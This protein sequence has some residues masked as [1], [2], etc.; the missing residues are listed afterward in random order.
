MHIIRY[1]LLA[2]FLFSF[3][4]KILAETP[5]NKDAIEEHEQGLSSA[6]SGNVEDVIIINNP[7]KVVELGSKVLIYLDEAEQLSIKR[8]IVG[9]FQGLFERSSQQILNFQMTPAAAWCKFSMKNEL[10]EEIFLEIG[11]SFMDSIFLYSVAPDSSFNTYIT[12]D[13]FPFEKRDVKTTNFLFKLPLAKGEQ[14]TFYLKLRCNEPLQFPLNAGSLKSIYEK[15]HIKDFIHGA[16]Y[17]FMILMVFY[18]LMFFFSTR[19]K[20][21]LYYILYVASITFFISNINGYYFEFLWPNNEWINNFAATSTAL[22]IFFGLLFNMNFLNLRE[23]SQVLFKICIALLPLPAI[24]FFLNLRGHNLEAIMFSQVTLLLVAVFFIISAVIIY[25]KGYK[26]AKFYVVAWSSVVASI[27][28]LILK[29]VN[30]LPY[31]VF[32]IN[33]LQIGV[34]FEVLLLSLAVADKINLYKKEK[35]A[36]Q[37]LAFESLK[38]KEMLIR[39]QNQ[40]LERKVEER[41]REISEKN[42][43]LHTQNEEIMAQAEAILEKSYELEGAL[44][45]ITA[46]LQYAKRIQNAILGNIDFITSRFNDAFILFYPRD[47]VSG[48]FYWFTEKGNIKIIIAADCTGH[49]VPGAFMTVM[50]NDFLNDIILN[51]NILDPSEILEELDQMIVA[52]VQ[53]QNSG[54]TPTK[55]GMDISVLVFDDD[56]KTVSFSGAKNPLYMVRNNEMEVIKAS[57][58]SIGSTLVSKADVLV[59]KFETHTI[60]LMRGDQFYILSDGYQD[61]FGGDDNR[62]FL[63]KRLRELLH[64]LSVLPMAQQKEKLDQIF[65]EWK[66]GVNQ[67]DD[68]L[69]IGV[70]Y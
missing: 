63:T 47:I 35:E 62:K 3:S 2:I 36:A 31:S 17:G 11:S 58:Y 48:D 65:A 69:V 70:R 64:E 8:L 20:I 57:K 39:E 18:N 24:I 22:T 68:V 54:S 16:F 12:G 1:L 42:Q 27:F 66:G 40:I 23:N 49:G 21:Y 37:K 53:K 38:E 25:R 34:T 30:V 45:N 52:T 28:V 14:K 19:E 55:D 67:T 51:K 4:G 59:K 33:S 60:Q 13:R 61:Q 50:G 32:T 15:D 6:S 10:D 44:N 5:E 41:T 26:P 9:E 43:E 46:S 7:D 29:D 56:A